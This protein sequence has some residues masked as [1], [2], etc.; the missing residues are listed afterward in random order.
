MVYEEVGQSVTFSVVINADVNPAPSYVWKQNGNIITTATTSSYT[1]GSIALSDAA[2]CTVTIAN[3][4]GTI[5]S[6]A[7]TLTC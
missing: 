2:V 7:V 4:A 3:S 6:Q 5:T 1:I